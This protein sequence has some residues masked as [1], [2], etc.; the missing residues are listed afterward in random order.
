VRRRRGKE[1]RKFSDLR[2]TEEGRSLAHPF[3]PMARGK[4]HYISPR[5]VGG[6]K[7][8]REGA[9]SFDEGRDRKRGR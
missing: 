5:A 2:G 1:R 9:R 8:G 4:K 7:R 6:R 3:M